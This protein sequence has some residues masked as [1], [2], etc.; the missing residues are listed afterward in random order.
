MYSF[1]A[2]DAPLD[3]LDRD[4][5][6]LARLIY[7]LGVFVECSGHH[8]ETPRLARDVSRFAAM[9]RYHGESAVRRSVLFATSRVLLTVPP[10][11]L[12][13][14]YV[15]DLAE[16]HAWLEGVKQVDSDDLCRQ[17]A[18]ALCAATTGRTLIA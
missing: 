9:A 6:I 3:L 15:V 4:H 14:G 2:H 17:Q 7:T 8:L 11:L 18:A 12:A 13:A 10:S 1:D 16:L 5:L